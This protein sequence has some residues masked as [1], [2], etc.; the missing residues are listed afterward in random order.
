MVQI[1]GNARSRAE[2]L[3][4]QSACLKD[5]CIVCN[6]GK[7][8]E[9]YET[10]TAVPPDRPARPNAPAKSRERFFML[11]ACTCKHMKGCV[12]VNH[13]AFSFVPPKP[14]GHRRHSHQGPVDPPPPSRACASKVPFM[15]IWFP[16]LVDKNTHSYHGQ[17]SFY[18]SS[19]MHAQG[20]HSRT[21]TG[22]SYLS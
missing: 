17:V 20:D 16:P 8:E 14:L 13:M 6:D 9:N 3:H 11:R 5:K 7:I 15:D 2:L 10:C 22:A 1:S 4:G 12:V 18:P 19:P 21:D